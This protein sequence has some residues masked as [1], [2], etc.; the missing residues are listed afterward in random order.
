MFTKTNLVKN[1]F[2]INVLFITLYVYFQNELFG[3]LEILFS[4]LS[5]IASVILEK[6]IFNSTLYLFLSTL[7]FFWFLSIFPTDNWGLV[8]VTLALSI[9]VYK[10]QVFSLFH[11]GEIKSPK[12]CLTIIVISLTSC[13]SLI[14]WGM[15]TNNLGGPATIIQEFRQQY[16]IIG[17]LFLIPLVAFLNAIVEETIFRGIIQTELSSIFNIYQ[18][19]FLQAILFAGAHYAVGFPNGVIGF[20]MTFIYAC[21]LGGMRYK[22]KGLLAPIITHTIADLAIMVFILSYSH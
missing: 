22:V 2:V 10:K 9:L 19:I 16:S 6:K 18:A 3:S 5:L 4:A 8:L 12:I 17:V 7:P 15:W 14:I 20:A 21:F 13:I 1:L 11:I